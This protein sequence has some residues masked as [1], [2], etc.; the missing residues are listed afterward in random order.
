MTTGLDRLK[1]CFCEALGVGPNADFDDLEYAG[2]SGWDSVAHMK[3]VAEIESTFDIMLDTD[4]VI[5]M[6]SFRVAKEIVPKYGVALDS[7]S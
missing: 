1:N 5:N 4:D 3:L 2:K 7:T 6:S